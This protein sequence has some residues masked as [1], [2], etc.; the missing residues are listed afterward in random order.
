[1]YLRATATYDDAAE[2]DDDAATRGVNE[3][4]LSTAGDTGISERKVRSSPSA[5]ARPVFPDEKE[6]AGEADPI[7]V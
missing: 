5:N 1:M 2:P 6:T 4:L 7:D 3:G